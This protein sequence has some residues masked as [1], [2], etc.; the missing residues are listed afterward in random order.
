MAGDPEPDR[1]RELAAMVDALLRILIDKGITTTK[2]FEKEQAR[3]L[4]AIDQV[5]AEEGF[6]NKL[7]IN[8][9]VFEFEPDP[10]GSG[11]YIPHVTHVPPDDDEPAE[12]DDEPPPP[13]RRRRRRKRPPPK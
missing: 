11:G 9:L 8:G 1:I 7:V 12:E 4:A 2:A 10:D 6:P 13:P 5:A 3:S